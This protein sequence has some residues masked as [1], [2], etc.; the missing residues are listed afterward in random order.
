[1][2]A[3]VAVAACARL[4]NIVGAEYKPDSAVGCTWPTWSEEVMELLQLQLVW[5]HGT[6]SFSSHLLRMC[7]C[8]L[9]QVSNSSS[10]VNATRSIDHTATLMT[11][12]TVHRTYDPLV[13]SP[14][15]PRLT[16]H[17]RNGLS[18]VSRS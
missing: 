17:V 6:E 12:H 1:M 5:Q 18:T 10:I 14:R 4:Q 7:E 3:A 13:L 11:R 15:R 2:P 8:W 9:Q 16:A